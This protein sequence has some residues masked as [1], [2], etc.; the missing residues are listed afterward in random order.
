MVGPFIG[1]KLVRANKDKKL[2]HESNI[3]TLLSCKLSW[4]GLLTL[5]TFSKLNVVKAW[6]LGM[7]LTSKACWSL[8]SAKR[9][10]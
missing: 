4:E 8:K 7:E 5:C 9:E 2:R 1:D 3:F 10:L 6:A